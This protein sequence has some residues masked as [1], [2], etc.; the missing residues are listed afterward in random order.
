MMKVIV[1]DLV[2]CIALQSLGGV[3]IPLIDSMR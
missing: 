3:K 2:M 1:M